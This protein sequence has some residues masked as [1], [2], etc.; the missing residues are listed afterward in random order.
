MGG[1]DPVALLAS[2]GMD[3]AAAYLQQARNQ[4]ADWLS[5]FNDTFFIY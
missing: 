4:N 2:I 1:N 3:D 5:F